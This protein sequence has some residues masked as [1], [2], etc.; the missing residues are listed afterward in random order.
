MMVPH[1]GQNGIWAGVGA[2]PILFDD[3]PVRVNRNKKFGDIEE[4]VM[5]DYP[6][7]NFKSGKSL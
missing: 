6:I 1:T 7:K 4:N 5:M 2:V 3:E